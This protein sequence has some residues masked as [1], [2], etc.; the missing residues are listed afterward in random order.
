MNNWTIIYT[1][2]HL[3]EFPHYETLRNSNPDA[4]ILFMDFS[5][6]LPR[7]FIWQNPDMLIRSWL[8]KNIAKIKHNNLAL[9]EYDVYVN[10]LLP[11]ITKDNFLYGKNYI[12]YKENHNWM[13]FD[14]KYLNKLKHLRPYA[15]GLAIFGL[16]FMSKN[17]LEILL[18]KQYDFL[19]KEDMNVELRF[20]TIMN[21][22]GVEVMGYNMPNIYLPAHAPPNFF[23]P[24]KPD[25]YHPVK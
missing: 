4:Q 15:C 3:G 10:T 9:V 13:W 2:N 1:S 25:F 17:V 24:N 7:Q 21:S 20:P 11:D 5:N 23:D 22:A 16:Y 8:K 14:D 19:Y 12:N 6:D 18:D